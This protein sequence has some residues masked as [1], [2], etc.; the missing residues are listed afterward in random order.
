LSLRQPCQLQGSFQFVPQH[1]W[2]PP[3]MFLSRC[4]LT[5]SI[6]DSDLLSSI[7]PSSLPTLCHTTLHRQWQALTGIFFWSPVKPRVDT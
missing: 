4:N 5:V 3:T 7:Q 1:S 6:L 2:S